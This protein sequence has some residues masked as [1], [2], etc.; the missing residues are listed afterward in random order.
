MRKQASKLWQEL[1]SHRTGDTSTAIVWWGWA[2]GFLWCIIR[3]MTLPLTDLSLLIID[4]PILALVLMSLFHRSCSPLINN[5]FGWIQYIRMLWVH[6]DC[7]LWV[8]D[9]WENSF[10]LYWFACMALKSGLELRFSFN[11]I[12]HFDT[13]YNC[14]VTPLFFWL[15]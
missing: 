8:D 4:S 6:N 13:F 3:Q 1:V 12:I 5:H 2:N 9:F 11:V 10:H 7:L 14:H 15:Q